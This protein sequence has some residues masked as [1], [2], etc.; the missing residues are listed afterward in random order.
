MLL[1]SRQLYTFVN[2]M[3][4]VRFGLVP[5]A[6]SPESTAQLKV[7]HYLHET[8]GLS[9]LIQYLEEVSQLSF[10]SYPNTILTKLWV[11]CVQDEAWESR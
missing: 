2:R 3:I 1:V 8:F 6:S 9:S 4:P 7:V 10:D 11:V 5:I